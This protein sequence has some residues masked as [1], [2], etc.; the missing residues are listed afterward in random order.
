VSKIETGRFSELLRKMLGQKGQEIVA[1][2]LSPEISPI[3][4]LEAA[5][6]DLE[7]YY[8]KGVKAI[9]FAQQIPLNVGFGG[10]ARITNPV[11]SGVI[12]TISR[13]AITCTGAIEW[14]VNIQNSVTLLATNALPAARDGR[15]PRTA[16][17]TQSALLA[18]VTSASGVVPTGA[19][20][21]HRAHLLP[22]SLGVYREQVVL[23]PG[24]SLDFG[25]LTG[26]LTVNLMAEW[27]ERP[28]TP[29]ELS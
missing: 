12:A 18:T 13:V 19:G 29:L 25:S 24:F 26:N 16:S 20:T 5:F 27:S 1:G 23:P 8:L 4:Q 22:T 3:F 2:E 10:H 11:A 17:L 15:W 28:V 21:L 7:W 14:V 9:G 6:P